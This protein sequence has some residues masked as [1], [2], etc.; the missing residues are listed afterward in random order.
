Q[1]GVVGVLDLFVEAAHFADVLLAGHGVDDAA[2]AEEQEGL[3]EGVGH[4]VKN[5]CGES[6]DAEGEKH[7]AELADG[8]IGENLLDVGL[9]E[10]HGGGEDRG[11][12]SHYGDYVQGDWR[13]LVDGVHAHDHVDAGGDH[14]GGVDEGA[15]GRG[16]FHGVRKPD[17]ERNLRG[18][19]HGA[20]EEQ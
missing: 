20:D 9:D 19:A 15:D 6:T 14:S 10:G 3:E 18:F 16:A 4:E 13:E 7:V 17:V 2:G 11:C 5:P 12:G 8:G 1:H